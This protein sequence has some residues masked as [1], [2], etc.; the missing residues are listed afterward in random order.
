LGQGD[1]ILF[2]K[3]PGVTNGHAQRGHIFYIGLYNKNIK[4][5]SWTTGRNAL[6]FGREHPWDKEIQV[7]SN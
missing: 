1:S 4:I 3:V 5:L 6:I 2:N 7:C